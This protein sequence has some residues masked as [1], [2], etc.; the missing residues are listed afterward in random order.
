MLFTVIVLVLV[1]FISSNLPWTRLPNLALG[2]T[3][4]FREMNIL[5]E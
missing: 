4:L 1:R 5:F 2:D 3:A